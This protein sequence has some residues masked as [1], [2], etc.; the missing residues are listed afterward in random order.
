MVSQVVDGFEVRVDGFEVHA[1]KRG[2]KTVFRIWDGSRHIYATNELTSD[3]VTRERL[4]ELELAVLKQGI[5]A[6]APERVANAKRD[7]FESPFATSGELD[8]PWK[9]EG[10]PIVRDLM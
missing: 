5:E 10:I 4:V 9:E 3:R 8:N 1:R 7:G 2:K 6:K